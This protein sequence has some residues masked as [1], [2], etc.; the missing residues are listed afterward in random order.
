M[1]SGKK[2]RLT[3]QSLDQK[4]LNFNSVARK[5]KRFCLIANR[6]YRR[7]AKELEAADLID[8]DDLVALA[9]ERVE[10]ERG[11]VVIDPTSDSALDLNTLKWLMVDEF[12]DFSPLFFH[13]IKALRTHNPALRLFCV[14]DDWQA[15]NGFA[16]SDLTSF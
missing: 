1:C 10:K 3:P 5:E 16:G 14:G 11:N 8:F 7:Y 12:Q 4:I 13:L 2:L 9:A 6:I 15:I